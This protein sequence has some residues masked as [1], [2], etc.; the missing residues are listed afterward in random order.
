MFMS[1]HRGQVNMSTI[2]LPSQRRRY[3]AEF[4]QRLVQTCH[5]GPYTRP[6]A[7]G[8]QTDRLCSPRSS[9]H[10]A[11]AAQVVELVPHVDHNL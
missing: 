4:K 6:E 2:E 7:V 9:S 11:Y 10:S 5:R 3:L 1:L 8:Q